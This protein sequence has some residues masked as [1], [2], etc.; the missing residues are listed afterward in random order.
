[1]TLAD[2]AADLADYRMR[3]RA[4]GPAAAERSY[5]LVGLTHGSAAGVPPTGSSACGWPAPSARTT[6]A[7]WCTTR[8]R[9]GTARVAGCPPGRPG[10][11][12]PTG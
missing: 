6:R 8:W 2:R 12:S 1:M 7:P 4:G 11:P 10:S 5:Y 9:S 3:M